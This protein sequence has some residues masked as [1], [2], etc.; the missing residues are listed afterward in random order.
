MGEVW[1]W[2]ELTNVMPMLDIQERPKTILQLASPKMMRT[3]RDI[4]SDNRVYNRDSTIKWK[5]GY[6][7]RRELSVG[8]SKFH[9]SSVFDT[10]GSKSRRSNAIVSCLL[11]L[12]I[13]R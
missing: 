9:G 11:N 4:R 13:D 5:L 8:I 2:V 7:S 3:G 10:I 12:I 6:L 1:V